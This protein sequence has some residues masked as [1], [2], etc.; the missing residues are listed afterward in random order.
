VLGVLASAREPAFPNVQT[1]AEQG[2]PYQSDM[3]RGIAA[4]KGTPRP[5]ILRLEAALRNTVNSPE[6][7]AQGDK[8]GFMAA[9][10]ASDDFGRLIAEDD[11]L[12]ERAMDKAG[13][14]IK[15]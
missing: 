2:I 13:L 6:F 5:V 4:P 14:L 12:V 11:R 8:M 15:K 3:W 10:A 9:F 1:A 7:R